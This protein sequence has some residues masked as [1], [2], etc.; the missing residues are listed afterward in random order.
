MDEAT[1]YEITKERVERLNPDGLSCEFSISA[2]QILSGG[3]YLLAYLRRFFTPK[4]GL[5][6]KSCAEKM[7]SKPY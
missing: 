6:S 5:Y 4:C 1:W 2:T 3:K 7:Q